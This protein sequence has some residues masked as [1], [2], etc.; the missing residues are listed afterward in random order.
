MEDKVEIVT[1]FMS[2][3]DEWMDYQDYTLIVAFND[4][5]ILEREFTSGSE[6]Y[7]ALEY[8]RNSRDTVYVLLE[9]LYY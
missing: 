5:F 9:E 2:N 8:Y 7:E 6:A 3:Y 1:K 4:G